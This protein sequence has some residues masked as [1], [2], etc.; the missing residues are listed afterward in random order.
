MPAGLPGEL[1]PSRQA[2]PGQ[3][4]SPAIPPWDAFPALEALHGSDP[5]SLEL[6]DDQEIED[7]VRRRTF[8]GLTSTSLL[9]SILDVASDERPLSAEPLV[10]IF[11]GH[12]VG[13]EL[14]EPGPPSDVAPLTAAVSQARRQYQAC[15]YAE[16]IRHLPQLLV[17]LHAALPVPG[18]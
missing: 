7:P 3:R 13:T 6:G 5:L 11:A 12:V 8:V 18:R 9:A 2:A 1:A 4:H 10:P 16:L 15:R 17:R 14:E